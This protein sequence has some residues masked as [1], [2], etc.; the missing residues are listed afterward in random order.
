M[1]TNTFST[2]DGRGLRIAIVRARFNE[3][4]TSKLLAGCQR[5]LRDAHVSAR[6]VLTVDVPGSFE[7]PFMAA[8][9]ARR[10]SKPDAIVCLGAI[11]KGETEH[12]VHIARAAS[13]GIGL[14]ARQYNLPVIF[15]VLT[16]RS[17]RQ[18]M[19]RTTGTHNKGYEAGMS[20][21][22]L[23]LTVRR[24]RTRHAL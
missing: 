23:A 20:A 17:L 12:D 7:L 22:E 14:V 16:T 4:V 1:K 10:R 2:L 5:A 3:T 21:V 13:L 8:H 24:L 15:G 11:I 6:S 18:A 9:L 19:A